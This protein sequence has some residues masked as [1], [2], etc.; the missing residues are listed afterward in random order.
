VATTLAA[1]WLAV[2]GAIATVQA[3][4]GRPHAAALASTPDAVAHGRLWTLL[5]SGLVIDGVPLAQLAGT[6]LVVAATVKAFGGRRFWLI[7][8][9]GHIGATLLTYLG[10][11]LL[12][13]TQV[14]DVDHVIDAPDY[15]VSAVWAAC[16]GALAVKGSMRRSDAVGVVSGALGVA[17][18]VV[19]AALVPRATGVDAVEHLLAFALGG[20]V[21]LVADR[22]RSSSGSHVRAPG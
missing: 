9:T 19:F 10:V 1:A 3:A 16:L 22:K 18:L 13:L 6:A 12:S 2:V 4:T 21:A 20:A 5:S 8:L 15:G 14:G 11:A 7:A 17:G